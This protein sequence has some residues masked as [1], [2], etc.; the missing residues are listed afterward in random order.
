MKTT[1]ALF[2]AVL[3]LS[4]AGNAAAQ[5]QPDVAYQKALLSRPLEPAD[6]AFC[7]GKAGEAKSAASDACRVTRLFLVDIAA[8]R[9]KGFPP[10]TDITFARNDAEIG[11]IMD[12]M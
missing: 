9:D 7:D 8:G 3:T 6:K 12:R 10:M 4:A 11:K 2:A 1:I 5:G